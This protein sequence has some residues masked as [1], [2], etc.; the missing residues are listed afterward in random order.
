MR[1][2]AIVLL[3]MLQSAGFAAASRPARSMPVLNPDA[4]APERCPPISRSETAR[5]SGKLGPHHL[6]ELPGADLYKAVYR[7]VGRCNVPII[8]RNNIGGSRR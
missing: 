5:R 1:L 7:H 2:L 4:G 8:V 6:D 3:I